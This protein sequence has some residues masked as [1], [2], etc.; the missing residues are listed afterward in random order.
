MSSWH[1][2]VR[3]RSHGVLTARGTP[4]TPYALPHSS[5]QLI[6]APRLPGGVHASTSSLCAPSPSSSAAPLVR[7]D[8]LRRTGYILDLRP[9]APGRRCRRPGGA[10]PVRNGYQ[11]GHARVSA[12]PCTTILIVDPGRRR[13][14]P[15]SGAHVQNKPNMLSQAQQSRPAPPTDR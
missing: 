14:W 7:S 10:T 13:P 11:A 6:R 5:F 9:P 15:A 8:S 3:Y 4:Q 12:R 2:K 1:K